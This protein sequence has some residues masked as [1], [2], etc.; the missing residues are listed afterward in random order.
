M[1]YKAIFTDSSLNIQS[2]L[3]EGYRN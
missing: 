1:R 3:R 2:I